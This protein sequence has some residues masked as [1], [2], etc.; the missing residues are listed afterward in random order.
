MF[1]CPWTCAPSRG[2][3]WKQQYRQEN[4]PSSKPGAMPHFYSRGSDHPL[5][6]Q[7][8]RRSAAG[9]VHQSAVG[10]TGS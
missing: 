9:A 8:L 5:H 1:V 2:T 10:F 7:A 6:L 3:F 4:A